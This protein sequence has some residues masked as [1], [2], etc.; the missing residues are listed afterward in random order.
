MLYYILQAQLFLQP[1][2][3]PHRDQILSQSEKKV[4]LQ[5]QHLR[6]KEHSLINHGNLRM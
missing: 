4:F 2:P 5:A 3:I 6:H 1:H